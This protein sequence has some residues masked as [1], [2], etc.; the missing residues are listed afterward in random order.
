VD[1]C[2]EINKH[3]K[4][5]V[6][7]SEHLYQF[8]DIGNIV[9]KD[10]EKMHESKW[11]WQKEFADT[12]KRKEFFIS[13]EKLNKPEHIELI[14]ASY[15]VDVFTPLVC[16]KYFEHPNYTFGNRVYDETLRFHTKLVQTFTNFHLR[17][18]F[19]WRDKID[20]LKLQLSD[21]FQRQKTRL[22]NLYDSTLRQKYFNSEFNLKKMI[23]TLLDKF[24]PN[25][26]WRWIGS[27]HSCH[28]KSLYLLV[29]TLEL[30]LWEASEIPELLKV[31]FNKTDNL[32][33]LEE[34]CIND[35]GRL[36]D[37]FKKEIVEVTSKCRQHIAYILLQVMTLLND[38]SF[39]A[40]FPF[41]DLR[42]GET[43]LEEKVVP[44]RGSTLHP[45]SSR[46]ATMK[47]NG[48][49]PENLMSPKRGYTGR[50][51]TAKIMPLNSS[52][53]SSAED[54][55]RS[56]PQKPKKVQEKNLL[57]NVFWKIDVL[58]KN[59]SQ[60]VIQYLISSKKINYKTLTTD[61]LEQALDGIFTY[62]AEADS[63]P[64]AASLD[65]VKRETFDY[66]INNSPQKK[67][68][69]NDCEEIRRM[70]FDTLDDVAQGKFGVYNNKIDFGCGIVSEGTDKNVC[71]TKDEKLQKRLVVICKCLENCLKKTGQELVN[72]KI[73]LTE[74]NMP[75]M[76]LALIDY[77]SDKDHVNENIADLEIV[78]TFILKDLCLDNMIGQG[79][80][81]KEMG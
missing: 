47:D 73:R 45:Q 22:T 13:F 42:F 49:Q 81:F 7:T 80:I 31:I 27:G 56:A 67:M 66:Y 76:L 61:L 68:I 37:A 29:V 38:S 44:K 23:Y 12:L 26:S 15:F 17:H 48:S 14:D 69:M 58:Y 6:Q 70:V 8:S 40:A 71:F 10:M 55:T 72:Y 2:I 36:G 60:I 20:T 43:S 28:E 35:Q 51:G 79:Q 50:G 75:T 74:D 25:V 9:E 16:Q 46:F 59:I 18:D 33:K 5:A 78:L 41:L 65:T 3:F 30:G 64:F 39:L 34:F 77:I 54:N 11:D 4:W 62:I 24:F 52:Q 1:D 21:P 63:D 19:R 53:I 57:K 32:V